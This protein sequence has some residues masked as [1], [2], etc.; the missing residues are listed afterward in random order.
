MS[1]SYPVSTVVPKVIEILGGGKRSARPGSRTTVKSVAARTETRNTQLGLGDN[2]VFSV[3]RGDSAGFLLL[4]GGD[5]SAANST[6]N[7]I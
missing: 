2:T 5:E 6:S 7:T 1:S 3:L 4:E